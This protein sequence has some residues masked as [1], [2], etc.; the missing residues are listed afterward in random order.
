M[1][2]LALAKP[3]ALLYTAPAI[4]PAPIAPYT[5][6]LAYSPLTYAASA[7]SYGPYA[8]N[9]GYNYRAPYAAYS[10]YIG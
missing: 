9:Y 1:L 4:A 7:Y 5:A 10:T 2:A 8:Y 6:P 3:G